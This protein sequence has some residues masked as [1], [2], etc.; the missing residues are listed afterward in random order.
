VARSHTAPGPVDLTNDLHE[1]ATALVDR[2]GAREASVRL[3]GVGASALVSRHE[4]RQ[5]G[6]GADVDEALAAASDEVRERFGDDML[7]P[8][9]L[10]PRPD[11]DRK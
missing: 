1:I 8:A 2:A 3:L 6:L 9:R 4:P 10:A 11:A 5:L 7:R